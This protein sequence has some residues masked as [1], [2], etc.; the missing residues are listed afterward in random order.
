M[1][2]ASSGGTSWQ[3][4]NLTDVKLA[5]GQYYLVRE[6]GAPEAARRCRTPDAL[7][8]IPMA[9]GAGKVALVSNQDTLQG[10][11]P[12]AGVVDFVG[13]GSGTNCFEGAPTATLSNTTAALRRGGGCVDTDQNSGDFAGRRAGAAQHGR[14]P[15]RV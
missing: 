15:Q 9:G 3:R 4:T 5:P 2:Y 14:R 1:Q 8:T 6:A 7:G 10:S 12:T 13:Y 11:C